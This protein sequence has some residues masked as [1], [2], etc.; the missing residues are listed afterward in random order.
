MLSFQEVCQKRKNGGQNR[1]Y[2]S[3]ILLTAKFFP[4]K[5]VLKNMSS[6]NLLMFLCSDP[7]SEP[8][9]NALHAASTPIMDELASGEAV[10]LAAHGRAVGLPSGLMGNSEVGHLN[11]GAGK[12]VYQVSNS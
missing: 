2:P 8:P 5:R 10:S 7:L 4:L 11:I 6:D 3:L 12:V 1:I 9:G